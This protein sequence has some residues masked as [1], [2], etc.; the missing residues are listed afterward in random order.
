MVF[1]PA[2]TLQLGA[3][4]PPERQRV[5]LAKTKENFSFSQQKR[6]RRTGLQLQQKEVTV[7]P[8]SKEKPSNNATRQFS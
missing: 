2:D 6:K 3:R 5:L 4:H 7:L 8:R 1:Q